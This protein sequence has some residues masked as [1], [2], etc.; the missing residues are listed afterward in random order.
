MTMRWRVRAKAIRYVL[1]R[2]ETEVD[3][4]AAALRGLSSHNL[5]EI[6]D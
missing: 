5:S 1:V 6:G 4:C 3:T 2:C